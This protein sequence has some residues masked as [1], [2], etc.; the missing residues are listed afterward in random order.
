MTFNRVELISFIQNQHHH[1]PGPEI[2]IS[3]LL[4]FYFYLTV[5]VVV[6]VVSKSCVQTPKDVSFKLYRFYWHTDILLYQKHT[7]THTQNH[8]MMNGWSAESVFFI[9]ESMF[10]WLWIKQHVRNVCWDC[11]RVLLNVWRDWIIKAYL[12]R[13]ADLVIFYLNYDDTRIVKGYCYCFC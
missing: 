1:R 2:R 10:Y 3:P 11:V 6:N 12:K 4:Y 5:V 7:N 9:N 8:R 13:C